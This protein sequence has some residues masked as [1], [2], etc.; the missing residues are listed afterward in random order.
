M[1][2]AIILID[3]QNLYYGLKDL[4]LNEWDINWSSF[5]KSLLSPDDK[6]LRTYWFRPQKI[7]DT[8]HTPHH[9]RSTI[10]FKKFNSY[11]H[12]YNQDSISV[13]SHISSQIEAE[14]VIVENWL[15]EVKEKFS[16]SEYKYDQISMDYEDIE[17]VKT[18]VVKV[19]P[20]KQAMIGEKGV[21]ISLAV[22]MI[23]LSVQKRC[24]KIYIG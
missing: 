11:S 14:A 8:F 1:S 4:S 2:N 23:A 24:D 13:P 20:H 3:G 21:D 6:L 17:V 5:F 7:L 12:L 22:K 10:C 19:D 16:K 15:K 18:G 9:I